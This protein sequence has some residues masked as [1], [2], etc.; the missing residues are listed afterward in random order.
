LNTKPETQSPAAAAHDEFDS[1]MM[2]RALELAARGA[3]R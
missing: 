3:G 1:R 2:A